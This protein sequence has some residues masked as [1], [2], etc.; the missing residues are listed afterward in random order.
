MKPY[1]MPHTQVVVGATYSGQIMIWDM[2]AKAAPVQRTTLSASGHTHPVYSLEIVGTPNAHQLVTVGN[3]GHMCMWSLAQMSEP[4]ES[5]KMVHKV[6]TH[7]PLLLVHPLLPYICTDVHPL[8]TFIHAY[9]HRIYTNVYP[10]TPLTCIYTP[11]IHRC[12]P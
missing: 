9:T 8:Y 5:R 12:L 2:R 1:N 4:T 11:Y 7:T 3:D 10:N 6:C